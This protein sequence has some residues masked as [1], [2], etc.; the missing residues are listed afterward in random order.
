MN[1]ASL[2][3]EIEKKRREEAYFDKHCDWLGFVQRILIYDF[4]NLFLLSCERQSQKINAIQRC[5]D[6]I[7]PWVC[8]CI[9]VHTKKILDENF[10]WSQFPCQM[11]NPLNSATI[12]CFSKI[13]ILSRRNQNTANQKN[14]KRITNKWKK[15][16]K[17]NRTK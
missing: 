9:C 1:C 6:A 14:E 13:C 5:I 15:W 2:A 11:L 10:C 4:C 12:N 3:T 8:V 17:K 7:V 16:K